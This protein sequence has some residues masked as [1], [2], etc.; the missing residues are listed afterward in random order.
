MKLTE[1]AIKEKLK[2]HGKQTRILLRDF[3][4]KFYQKIEK[5]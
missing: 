1:K 4:S 2:K 5:N 3:E